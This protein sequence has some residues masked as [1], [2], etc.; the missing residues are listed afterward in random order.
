MKTKYGQVE[1][2]WLLDC[3]PRPA[4]VEA[5]LRGYYGFRYRAHKEGEGHWSPLPWSGKPALGYAYFMEM[6][7]GKTP[8]A[9]NEFMLLK[10]DHG[11]N[12]AFILAPN[13][14]K[15]AWA[16]EAGRFGVDVP[17]HVFESRNRKAFVQF[18]R[19]IG[20][21][22]GIVIVNYEALTYDENNRLFAKFINNKTY[23]PADESV[24]IKNPQSG[25]F[26][27]GK[28]LSNSAAITRVLTGLPSP[29]SVCDLWSQLRFARYLDGVNFYAFRGKYAKMGGFKNK[30][31]IGRKNED[32]LEK[33][34]DVASFR[35][36]RA[37]WGTKIACEYD[38]CKLEMLP[39]QKKAYN[40]MD[41]DFVAWLDSGEMITAD[42]VITKRMKMQQ[43]SSGFVINEHG[44][45]LELVPFEKTPKF[46]DLAERLDN[47]I[48]SKLI[49]IAHYT[50]TIKQLHEKLSKHGVACITGN[51]TMKK[52]GDLNAE[53]E[54]QR[55][56]N[57]PNCRVMIGQS[58]AIKYGHTL[59]GTRD[60]PCLSMVFFE[61]NYS[62]DNRSQT[63]E[64]PQ[65]EGQLDAIWMLDYVSSGIEQDIIKSLQGKKSVAEAIMGWYGK[66]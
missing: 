13:K 40:E 64:R 63:E 50:H 37:D 18:M 36:R 5:I 42:Q 2:D 26:K 61:N 41:K 45:P 46:K 14:Y 31:I 23:M 66:A 47:E 10:R 3:E 6:R 4:Q 19:E 44:K 21:G 29:Q 33:L 30:K 43:I 48:E 20:D 17:V 32:H 38:T 62:L 16:M 54:K 12:R 55:F 52:L 35:A 11:I 25:F 59:M 56:N 27:N 9:L 24:L 8:T 65:G 15:Y 22:E 51:E 28:I 7:T 60:D 53:D 39:P 1:V 49:V 57:D 34:L 58:Q